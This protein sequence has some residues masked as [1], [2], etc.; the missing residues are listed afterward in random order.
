[1]TTLFKTIKTESKR[2]LRHVM[3]I[4]KQVPLKEWKEKLKFPHLAA[5]LLKQVNIYV[6]HKN[7]YIRRSQKDLYFAK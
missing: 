7:F 4:Y 6:W 3:R 5:G 2:I 1:M